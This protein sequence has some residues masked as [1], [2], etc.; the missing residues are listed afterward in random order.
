MP[1]R[2][3]SVF[4][5]IIAL[6]VSALF[7]VRP[8]PIYGVS[9]SPGCT[10]GVGDA[11]A[12]QSAVT[13]A[14]SNSQD[15]TVTLVSGCTYA[16]SSALIIFADNT[17]TLTITTTGSAPATLR[18]NSSFIIL[19]IRSGAN[20][21]LN[22]LIVTNGFEIIAGG[23]AAFRATLTVTNSAISGNA[24]TYFGGGL[25]VG[26]STVT[27]TNSTVSGNSAGSHGGGIYS[28]N[29]TLTL[30]NSAVNINSASEDGGGIYQD[31]GT[32]TLNN[33]TVSGN[34]SIYDG[35]GINHHAGVTI[36][37]NSI[38]SSNSTSGDGLGGGIY[39]NADAASLTV[40]NSTISANYGGLGG[41][42]TVR[43]SVTLNNS[44]LGNSTHGGD[45]F[46]PSGTVTA[47]YSLIEDGECINGLSDTMPDTNGN[48][49]G[50]P[51]LDA[52]FVPSASRVIDRGNPNTG[53]GYDCLSTDMMGISRNDGDGDGVD[54]CDM[55]AREGPVYAP[56]TLAIAG[57]AVN[58]GGTTAFTLM[59]SGGTIGF[60]LVVNL[61]LSAGPDLHFISDYS[62]S[63]GSISD[64]IGS[65]TATI[66]AGADHVDVTFT[67][68]NDGSSAEAAET[69]VAQL[70][71]GNGYTLGTT[72]SAQ[73]TINANGLIATNGNDSGEGSLRQAVA[74]ANND[75][76]DSTITFTTN[77]I[78]LTSGELLLANDGALT[79]V[80]GGGLTISGDGSSFRI[81]EISSGANVTLSGLTISG[82]TSGDGGGIYNRASLVLDRV[83]VAANTATSR[84]GGIF[85]I[86]TLNLYNSIVRDN[87]A[88]SQGGG[89]FSG[90]TVIPH[91]SV[92]SGNSAPYGAGV[93]G[94]TG[95][96]MFNSIIAYNN[97]GSDCYSSSTFSAFSSV[98]E[99]GSCGVSGTPLTPD[100]SNT[101]SGDPDL[102]PI[103][104]IPNADSPVINSG[105]NEFVVSASD[106]GGNPRIQGG[107]V[108]RGAYETGYFPLVSLSVPDASALE[109]SADTGTFTLT[110]TQT[111]T[112]VALDVTVTLTGAAVN[113]ADYASIPTTITIP[114]G[115]AS[116]DVMVTAINNEA[117]D[118]TRTVTLT[119][120]DGTHYDLGVTSSGTVAITDDDSASVV[121]DQSGGSTDVAEG[122]P[123][124]SFTIRLSSQP[125]EVVTITLTPDAQIALDQSSLVFDETMWSTPQTVTVVTIDDTVAQG[126]RAVS[127]GVVVSSTSEPNYNSSLVTPSI[128]VNIADNDSSGIS[129]SQTSFETAEGLSGSYQIALA[130]MPSAAPI[131]ITVTF[132]HTQLRA[133]GNS[134]AFTLSFNDTTPQIVTFDV[135]ANFDINSDRTITIT[136]AVTNSSASEYPL[137]THSDVSV[138]V[139]DQLP[140]PPSPTCDT[141]NFNENGVVRTGI[142]NAL[143]Y[144]INCRILYYNGHSTTWLGHD[145]YSEANLGVA[146]L[147][148]LGVQQAVDIFSPSGMT[149]FEGGAVFCLRGQ[150]TL[151]WLAASGLPRRPEIIGSYTVPDFPSFTCATLFEPGTFVLVTQN[152]R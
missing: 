7:F 96:Q 94:A 152:P 114:A 142:P 120:V 99:D 8:A 78:Y 147:L 65:V 103:T 122:G 117:A 126:G 137:G 33:S 149:Y 20:V 63:G 132:D 121:I 67:A 62:L 143:A 109:N 77:T 133:N 84:G 4:I 64:Q 123:T 46:L 34:T 139:R 138:T 47:R 127:I 90:A 81:L 26:S 49:R 111:S 30:N 2:D 16:I 131:V 136:H 92:I 75:G 44:I 29:S 39:N 41:G 11:A 5:L 86:G 53:T 74:N 31:G 56:S 24:T 48:L 115:L 98:I 42:I 108:D 97:G 35:G 135:L 1:I 134:A 21:S 148:D 85:N 125:S 61:I 22:N 79:I 150:G 38:V 102:D 87:M 15:D 57:G 58:E 72:T 45:C 40:N 93:F 59:R 36:L 13:T 146:G 25:Y 12:L 3:R 51:S 91:N 19:D 23:I 145:L 88:A 95:L 76:V 10:G 83:I 113:G 144:A 54:R 37:N 6:I 140:P 100:S 118:G 60:S 14:N 89:I 66:P 116:V 71:P 128:D 119:V 106:L 50:D 9:F 110:R 73:A 55:G 124:D 107:T 105:G 68:V 141:E 80:G 151:I 43:A 17:H 52:S 129:I 130:S 70:I 112:V 27:L 101:F 32:L 18:G 69:L 28:S 104:L 82:G